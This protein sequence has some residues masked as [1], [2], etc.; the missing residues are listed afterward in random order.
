[1]RGNI[2]TRVKKAGEQSCRNSP[3][4]FVNGLDPERPKILVVDDH[5][6]SRMTAAAL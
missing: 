5:S 3:A 4:L 1:M 6:A 2:S